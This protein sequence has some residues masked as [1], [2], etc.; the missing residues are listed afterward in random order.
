VDSHEQGAVAGLTGATAGAGFIFGPMIATGLY[1]LSP[2][3]PYIFGAGLMAACHLYAL[4][5]PH[6]RQAGLI[7]A[8]RDLVDDAADS[9]VPN[10]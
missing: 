5:S 8:A 9:L 2:F 4:V 3:A 7:S 10:V 6:L 1:R